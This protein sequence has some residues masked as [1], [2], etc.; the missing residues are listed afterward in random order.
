MISWRYRKN[1][2]HS[3]QSNPRPQAHTNRKPSA[4]GCDW[5]GGVTKW[6][7]DGVK[8]RRRE[9]YEVRDDVEL[10][11]GI[12]PTTFSLRVRCS[13][14]EPH[15]QFSLSIL[16][17]NRELVKWWRKKT[18]KWRRKNPVMQN[19]GKA[20]KRLHTPLVYIKITP[21]GMCKS[22]PH[23]PQTFPQLFTGFIPTVS[24]F[25]DYPQCYPQE[26]YTFL[27]VTGVDIKWIQNSCQVNYFQISRIFSFKSHDFL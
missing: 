11:V 23:F 21:K 19:E 15:Q 9:R 12:E 2:Y 13:A 14:I 27:R 26:F 4:A 7:S 16:P 20:Q 5:K 22:Y 24:G 3:T 6:V 18:W 10:M 25:P 8:K 1:R 17:W